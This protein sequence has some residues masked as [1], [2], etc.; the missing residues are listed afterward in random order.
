[1]ELQ[2]GLAGLRIW[3]LLV[4]A[5]LLFNGFCLIQVS[6][7]THTNRVTEITGTILIQKSLTSYS[8]PCDEIGDV[9]F[10]DDFDSAPM[11]F[12]SSIWNLYTM[13]HPTL[14]WVDG[15]SLV[16]NSEMFTQ[17]TLESVQ[18]TG[19]EVVAEFNMSYSGGDNYFG[20]GW[21]DDFQD[22]VNN[23]VSNLRV[24]QNGVFL[25][26]WDGQLLLVSSVDGISESTVIKGIDVEDEHVY[27]LVWSDSLVRLY[28]DNNETGF[29]SQCVPISALQFTVTISGYNHLVGYDQLTIDRIGLYERD[30]CISDGCPRISL[31]WPENSSTVFDFDE[32]DMDIEGED[33]DCLY[34]WDG[35]MNASFSSPWDIPVPSSIGLHHLDVFANGFENNW[36][37]TSMDFTVTSQENTLL[38]PDSAT[39]PLIDGFISEKEMQSFALIDSFLRGEDRS[40][41]PFR[42][43]IGYY[44]NSLYV[45][46]ITTLQDEYHSRI[47]LLIDGKGTGVWGDADFGSMEDIRVTSEAPLAD[48]LY[49]GVTTHYGEE[50]SPVGVVYDSGLS[51]WGVTAEFLVPIQSVGGNSSKGLAM[52]L[53]VS[54]GGFD[55]YFPMRASTMTMVI[56]RSSGP[57][58]VPSLYGLAFV[59]MLL[60]VPIAAVVVA[61]IRGKRPETQIEMTL[62][63]EN[64]ERVRT[65][66]LSHPEI[67]LDRLALLANT[68]TKS[69]KS[70]I[71][72]LILEDLIDSTIS[73][74]DRGVIR[75]LAPSE[76]KQ[77]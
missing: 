21:A 19:P 73:I 16:L 67:S 54:Q 42:L 17:A 77:K 27:R 61:V 49:R 64:L 43:L 12:N 4:T 9:L 53:V 66:L 37:S 26:F 35:A 23:W 48:Q 22:P 60:T 68:D 13:N 57:I 71:E 69:V 46:A 63:D 24:C 38:M 5:M 32:I 52:S 72:T 25:D 30:L 59:I 62:T 47:S 39:E 28:I 34:S 10:V 1:M 6:I 7:P 36:S 41:I 15:N 33:G 58:L 31:V 2:Q 8:S 50:V 44:N 29:V 56:V 14:S 75:P 74:T 3:T 11:G 70:T 51:E 18:T 45:G 40:E 65:L 76:K 55:S 20:L